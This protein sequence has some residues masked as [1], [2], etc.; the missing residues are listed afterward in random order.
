[1]PRNLGNKKPD[2]P[3]L[4]NVPEDVPERPPP[5]V[6]EKLKEFREK[7]LY[8]SEGSLSGQ[9]LNQEHLPRKQPASDNERSQPKPKQR[10][11]KLS[12]SQEDQLVR[13]KK[14]E[15][16]SADK[17]K[18]SPKPQPR[19]RS[20]EQQEAEFRNDNSPIKGQSRTD[21]PKKYRNKEQQSTKSCE[22]GK[23]QEHT[24]AS[25]KP[26]R[27]VSAPEAPLRSHSLSEEPSDDQ[28]KT[29]PT[30]KPRSKSLANLFSS[31]GNWNSDKG[32][33]SES[34]Q[35]SRLHSSDNSSLGEPNYTGITDSHHQVHCDNNQNIT[36]FKSIE[37]LHPPGRSPPKPKP[38]TRAKKNRV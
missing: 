1:L 29:R 3:N 15:M 12:N 35:R 9:H 18:V 6:P 8:S 2:K 5:P 26:N 36:G 31:T 23:N 33:I 22:E 13:N 20:Q 38:K 17:N 10:D 11:R 16:A 25:P 34:Q 14:N 32:A 37:P 24:T 7:R 21:D 4:R 27:R 28:P 19:R 30:I